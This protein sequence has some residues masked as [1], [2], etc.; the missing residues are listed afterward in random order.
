M[1]DIVIIG[2]GPAGAIFAQLIDKRY[3][4]CIIDKRDLANENTSNTLNKSC[5]ALLA[6]AAQYMTAKLGLALPKSILV[7]PRSFSQ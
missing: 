2:A 7:D 6:P 5:G 1:Y 4:V 3:K